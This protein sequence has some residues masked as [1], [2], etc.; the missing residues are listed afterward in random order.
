MKPIATP[1][2]TFT[3]EGLSNKHCVLMYALLASYKMG[4]TNTYSST[5]LELIEMLEALDLDVDNNL[6]LVVSPEDYEGIKA[7]P[8]IHDFVLELK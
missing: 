2:K 5:A 4:S 8:E 7:G 3:V 1:M 6:G